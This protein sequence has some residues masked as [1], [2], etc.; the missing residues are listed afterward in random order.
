MAQAAAALKA[1]RKPQPRA[2]ELFG[3][4]HIVGGL[5]L[6]LAAA[7]LFAVP[8]FLLPSLILSSTIG[9]GLVVLASLWAVA[10]P[11]LAAG[12]IG[13]RFPR[14]HSRYSYMVPRA[15][16]SVL[17]LIALG[18]AVGSLYLL[19]TVRF[20]LLPPELCAGPEALIR[21]LVPSLLLVVA[22]RIVRLAFGR[23]RLAQKYLFGP[24][25]GG[26]YVEWCVWA[27]LPAL[28]SLSAL[29][30]HH[31]VRDPAL[32]PLDGAYERLLQLHDARSDD[33]REALQR[34][35]RDLD[36][37]DRAQAASGMLRLIAAQAE[38]TSGAL[39]L[40]LLGSEGVLWGESPVLP[41][42]HE[43]IE[44]LRS[45]EWSVDATRPRVGAIGTGT[46]AAPRRLDGIR[47]VRDEAVVMRWARAIGACGKKLRTEELPLAEQERA[48]LIH[49]VC[50]P[51]IEEAVSA[52]QAWLAASLP[53]APAE[54]GTWSALGGRGY[55]RVHNDETWIM[56]RQL[57]GSV[58][59]SCER[60]EDAVDALVF[61]DR[62][63][64]TDVPCQAP[65]RKGR[66]L[67][68][69][70]PQ[71]AGG[72]IWFGSVARLR[73]RFKVDPKNRVPA[74][75][76]APAMPIVDV[77]RTPSG[78]ACPAGWDGPAEASAPD[79]GLK[80]ASCRLP[81]GFP[82]ICSFP[83]FFVE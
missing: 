49:L 74:G 45:R 32:R 65:T 54:T 64:P 61:A 43:A 18:T 56:E 21:L 19:Y 25:D 39:A 11:L 33:A 62:G 40:K 53:A 23:R 30:A 9:L 83:S 76:P 73:K 48:W 46:D 13:R 27:I 66:I 29:A 68:L 75:Q 69:W 28:L 72:A 35:S 57:A 17:Y 15:S 55:R 42:R 41:L 12:A 59:A 37:G 70:L 51:S 2:R 20:P 14:F 10:A 31:L 79:L 38:P 8:Y 1:R 58:Y 34:M 50:A 5:G 77:V 26:F 16:R 3:A 52:H 78:G 80:S 71:P 81:P 24:P 36:A 44:A 60:S 47:T 63:T 4:P 6:A 82:K 7:V 22:V 67:H